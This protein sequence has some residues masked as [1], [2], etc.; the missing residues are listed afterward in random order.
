MV[1]C[2]YL[3]VRNSFEKEFLES[4]SF[5]YPFV[6]F[7]CWTL[8]QV[9][10][11]WRFILHFASNSRLIVNMLIKKYTPPWHLSFLPAQLCYLNVSRL[12]SL[13][14]KLQIT[15]AWNYFDL[16]SGKIWHSNHISVLES[17]SVLGSGVPVNLFASR[18]ACKKIMV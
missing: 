7:V 10:N 15:T 9:N 1:W 3:I 12:S 16:P 13:G 17:V 4:L 2:N 18:I 8:H 6:Y 11:I 14:R 5:S